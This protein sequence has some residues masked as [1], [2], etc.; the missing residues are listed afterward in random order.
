MQSSHAAAAVSSAFDDPNLIAYGGLEP[1]MRLAERCGLPALADQLIGLPRSKDGTGAFPAAKLMSLVGGMVA[2]A[3]SIDDMDRL[4]HGATGRLF[5]GVRAPST[6]GSFLRSF[7][8]GHVKQLHAVARRLI[9]RLTAHTPLLPGADQV[10]YVDIDDTIRR[11][12]GYAKQGTGYGY[13]KVKGLNALLGIVSTPL[14]APVIAATRLRKGPTNSARGAAAFVAETIRTAHACG[15]SGLLVVRADSAFYGADVVSTC[16]SLDARFSITVRMNASVKKAI[17]G[18]D[19]GTWTAIKYPKAVWD[20]E[21]QC[22]ISDAEIAETTYTAF[23]SKPKKQQVTAR[24]IVRRVKR[25]NPDS[26]PAGQG[27]LFDTWRYHAA[28]TDSPLSLKDAERDHRRHAVVEQVIADVKNSAFAHAPS[29][30]FQA[31]AAWL[32]LA[33]LA[34]NLTRAAGTLA[35]AFHARAATATIRDHLINVPARLARSAR[36]LTLHLPERWPWEGDFTQL[37]TAVHAPPPSA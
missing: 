20:E 9:P 31:N 15:A 16:R 10:A 32:T 33:A 25:L 6:L 35:G 7:T 28:F 30:N 5:A 26:L 36:R 17:A 37:F 34:H 13:S 23:T 19:E 24:L 3:D 21:G 4:R 18:I 11:T 27:T 29:G 8:H 1:V 14:A 12:Y 22:W 2:G